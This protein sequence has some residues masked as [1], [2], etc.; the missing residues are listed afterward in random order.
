M[1]RPR[2][3][4]GDAGRRPL[5]KICGV[6]RA[7]DALAAVELGADL[8]GLNF[9]PASPRC[10]PVERAAEVA[11]AVRGRARLV[12][13]FVRHSRR[14]VEAVDAC[15]GLDLLQFHGDQGPRE[16]APFAARA[17]KVLR[18][19]PG[20]PPDAGALAAEAER[21]PGAWGFLLDAR[22]DHLFGGTGESW[23]WRGATGLASGRPWLVAGGIRPGNARVAL[24]AS[25]AS[26]IDVCSGV[27]AAPG[28]KD[29]RKMARLFAEIADLRREPHGESQGA[30]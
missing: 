9:H 26:G 25:G 5:V 11:A 3:S 21:Y 4:E 20:A 12:G 14:E 10:V 27:E 13:V 17:V 2:A 6:T 7:E 22:H 24:V 29:A 28:V 19:E 18:L 8:V 16:L 23:D 30:A 15:L 1:H